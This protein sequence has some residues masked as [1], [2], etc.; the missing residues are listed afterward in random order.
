MINILLKIAYTKIKKLLN[1]KNLELML[2]NSKK[3]VFFYF[4]W[5]NNSYI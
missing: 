4:L 1:K 2:F 3:Y 5:Y